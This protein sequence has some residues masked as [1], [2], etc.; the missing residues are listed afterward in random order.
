MGSSSYT[1]CFAIGLRLGYDGLD[2]AGDLVWSLH[3]AGPGGFP[4]DEELYDVKFVRNF[5]AAF[6]PNNTCVCSEGLEIRYIPCNGYGSHFGNT[7][8]HLQSLKKICY[9]CSII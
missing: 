9:S 1:S 7:G 8:N 5:P 3:Y 2:D 4:L 6:D